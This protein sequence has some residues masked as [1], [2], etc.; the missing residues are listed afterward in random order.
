[1]EGKTELQQR[2]QIVT[3]SWVKFLENKSFG[4]CVQ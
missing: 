4:I 1:M 2:A 3:G